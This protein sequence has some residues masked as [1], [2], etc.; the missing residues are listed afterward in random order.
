M[1]QQVCGLALYSAVM[2]YRIASRALED[3]KGLIGKAKRGH[4]QGQ[5]SVDA[6]S[7]AALGHVLLAILPSYH[8]PDKSAAVD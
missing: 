1:Q 7:L 4:R 2:Q 6:L 3:R 5:V 8:S